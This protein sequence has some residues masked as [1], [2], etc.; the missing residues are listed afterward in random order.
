[1]K[2]KFKHE[3]YLEVVQDNF[4]SLVDNCIL[5]DKGKT[6]ATKTMAVLL[7][8]LLHDTDNGSSI[9]LLKHLGIKEKMLFLDTGGRTDGD[10]IFLVS[11]LG[12]ARVYSRE[13]SIPF[14]GI[15]LE[16]IFVPKCLVDTPDL[17][18]NWRP[19][20][21][22]FDEWWNRKIIVTNNSKY[23]RWEIIRLFVNKYG[24]AHINTS[25][26]EEFYEL[27]KGISSLF[28]SSSVSLEEDPYVKGEPI[29]YS[30]HAIV[31]QVA[32]EVI[33]SILKELRFELQDEYFNYPRKFYG[34]INLA[35]AAL[36]RDK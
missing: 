25:I 21:I 5:Y 12:I 14:S 29:K 23:S 8:T 11:L 22:K 36:T 1:M 7:R 20:Y 13:K 35:E 17:P 24:G 31:R 16:S 4:E 32:H 19:K 33:L 3:D 9:S 6:S 27:S 15:R 10:P 18:K 28:Y 30:L 2:I 34:K 26:D